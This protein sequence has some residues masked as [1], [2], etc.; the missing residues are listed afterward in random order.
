VEVTATG[1]KAIAV[2]GRLAERVQL[3]LGSDPTRIAWGIRMARTAAEQAGR[4]P[5]D[6]SIGAYALVV[7]CRKHKGRMLELVRPM[8]ATGARFGI[9][10]KRIVVP[11]SPRE[12]RSLEGLAQTYDMSQHAR[13]GQRAPAL[14]DAFVDAYAIVGPPAECAE[15]LQALRDLGLERFVVSHIPIERPEHDE[16][17]QLFVEEVMPALRR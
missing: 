8:V 14:D 4:N 11:A 15:R 1:P 10:E 12:R 3:T 6:L 17:H 2:G 7:P 9:M 5:D 13:A 16:V